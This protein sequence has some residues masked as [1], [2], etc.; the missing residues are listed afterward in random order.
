MRQRQKNLK[1]SASILPYKLVKKAGRTCCLFKENKSRTTPHVAMTND[2]IS[3]ATSTTQEGST[4]GSHVYY[5]DEN[6]ISTIKTIWDVS[7]PRYYSSSSKDRSHHLN[8]FQV[9]DTTDNE[10]LARG[11]TLESLQAVTSEMAKKQVYLRQIMEHLSLPADDSPAGNN[12]GKKA[13]HP[14]RQ[15]SIFT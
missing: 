6:S 4:F 12:S 10:S 13:M 1:Q 5:K 14:P 15:P 3:R 9:V 7:S 8:N 11:I 2:M